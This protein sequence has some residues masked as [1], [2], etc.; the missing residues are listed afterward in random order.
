MAVGL[1]GRVPLLDNE[2]VAL[3]EKTPEERMMSL[4]RGKIIL[5]E[6]ANRYAPPTTNLKRGFAVPLASYF[7]GPW[8]EEAREWF[9]SI[10]SELVDGKAAVRLLERRPAPVT[11]LWMLATLAAWEDRLRHARITRVGGAKTRVL[12]S[13]S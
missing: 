13:P 2:F 4:R 12:A 8:R 5:R 11:D 3:A 1:E 7:G 9:G 10:D 6:L